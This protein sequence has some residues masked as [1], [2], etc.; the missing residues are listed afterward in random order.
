[1]HDLNLKINC[2]YQQI[3][4]RHVF[5]GCNDA[6][7]RPTAVAMSSNE[8]TI[9]GYHVMNNTATNDDESNTEKQCSAP[10]CMDPLK[11]VGLSPQFWAYTPLFIG[12]VHKLHLDP[13]L[14]LNCIVTTPSPSSLSST[15]QRKI[16]IYK[17]K[18]VGMI[19]C[20]TKKSTHVSYVLDDGTGCIDCIAWENEDIFSLPTSLVTLPNSNQTTKFLVGD[21]CEV[22][23]KLKFVFI[24]SDYYAHNDNSSQIVREIQ[25]NIMDYCE[26]QQDRTFDAPFD[27]VPTKFY[28]K[29]QGTRE[30]S[31]WMQ[32]LHFIRKCS[33]IP[34]HDE[35]RISSKEDLNPTNNIAGLDMDPSHLDTYCSFL[36]QQL[37]VPVR[38]GEDILSILPNPSRDSIFQK[39]AMDRNRVGGKNHPDVGRWKLFGPACPCS[40]TNGVTYKNTLLYCHCVATK[41][42]LDPNFNFRD[43]LLSKLTAMEKQHNTD[44]HNLSQNHEGAKSIQHV[45]TF[46]FRHICQDPDLIAVAHQVTVTTSKPKLNASSI[47]LQTFSALRKDGIVFLV[48]EKRDHYMLISTGILF[49][50]IEKTSNKDWPGTSSSSDDTL[51]RMHLKTHRPDY[52]ERVHPDRLQ[53][54]SDLFSSNKMKRKR[55]DE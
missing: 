26:E 17:C 47:F 31:H 19:T 6:I 29:G 55:D 42:D 48:D 32:C 33:L 37:H 40:A 18:L 28:S 54:A 30:M 21:V 35:A 25:V 36:K 22:Y 23:G 34:S 24:P 53:V 14:G 3:A 51:E 39:R 4:C 50:Y 9:G 44:C 11:I 41:V 13:V 45:L 46:S 8:T 7:D 27:Q 20:A 16:A 5:L 43:L 38:T 49:T 10:H 2:T 12:D 1:M 15:S 52:L